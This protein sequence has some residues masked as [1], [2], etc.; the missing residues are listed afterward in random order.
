MWREAE[1]SWKTDWHWEDG[2]EE[3]CTK[4]I[5]E[6]FFWSCFETHD[7]L[8]EIELMEN[9]DIG[10]KIAND[11]FKRQFNTLVVWNNV[12]LVL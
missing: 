11:I 7:Y 2:R 4:K 3:E 9:S 10:Q 1:T 12:P 8:L 5:V 6:T